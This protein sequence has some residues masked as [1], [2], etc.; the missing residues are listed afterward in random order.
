MLNHWVSPSVTLYAH[1]LSFSRFHSAIAVWLSARRRANCG[2]REHPLT[3]NQEEHYSNV[4]KRQSLVH[5]R[6]GQQNTPFVHPRSRYSTKRQWYWRSVRQAGC[7]QPEPYRHRGI[8]HASTIINR[9]KNDTK[10]LSTPPLPTPTY[11]SGEHDL[12]ALTEAGSSS[13]SSSSSSSVSV[14]LKITPFDPRGSR[15]SC[16]TARTENCMIYVEYGSGHE[17]L[18]W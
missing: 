16:L 17:R 7:G 1:S 15:L 5:G 6:H 8:V 2:A 10:R 13:P 11:V 4:R 3:R 9:E 18:S 12:K 14:P